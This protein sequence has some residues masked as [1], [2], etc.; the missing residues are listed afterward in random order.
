MKRVKVLFAVLIAVVFIIS[1]IGCS[2]ANDKNSPNDSNDR[3]SSQTTE[4]KDSN[5]NILL[6]EEPS[7]VN[8]VKDDIARY[9]KNYGGKVNYILTSWDQMQTKLMTLVSAGSAP[10]AT[11]LYEQMMP[12]YALKKVVQPIEKYFDLKDPLWNT[13]SMELFKFNGNYYGVHGYANQV[14][15]IYYNKTMFANNGLETPLE[16]YNKGE[17]N[18][19]NFQ[20]VA[21]ELTQDT[22]GDGNT[23]QWGYASWMQDLFILSNGGDFVRYQDNGSISLTIN[24]PEVLQAL[25]FEQD[26]FKKHKFEHPDGGFKWKDE[27]PTGKIAMIAER[28]FVAGQ[29]LKDKMKDEWDIAPFPVGP[30]GSKDVFPGTFDAWG[31]PTGA[32]NPEGGAAYIKTIYE[33]NKENY[34]ARRLQYF[35]QDQLDLIKKM[36]EN[37]LAAGGYQGIA[38][39]QQKSWKLFDDVKAGIPPATAV[40]TRSPELQKEIDTVLAD[41]IITEKDISP[42]QFNIE[43]VDIPNQEFVSG[44]PN[45]LAES[46]L[47]GFLFDDYSDIERFKSNKNATGG[48]NWQDKVGECD[49]NMLTMDGNKTTWWDCTFSPEESNVDMTQYNY[50]V[51]VIKG[52]AGAKLSVNLWDANGQTTFVP[53]P[54]TDKWQQVKISLDNFKNIDKTKITK[55]KHSSIAGKFYID[56]ILFTK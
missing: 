38:G 17:W 54:I 48:G 20:K 16:Y 46:E 1:M 23:D 13:D 29:Y 40:A 43:V 3:T 12:K 34:D 53:V 41:T 55:F 11:Y 18:W 14:A 27:F 8:F 52:D 44:S 30:K 22:D 36:G 39:L 7:D 19:D 51:Y 31:I 15:F 4:L 33:N 28:D 21:I 35:T 45:L 50:L 24:T 10:D 25:Q 56:E 9:E 26:A 37:K 32:K 49:G 6:W 47:Q 42:N 2:G 5:I